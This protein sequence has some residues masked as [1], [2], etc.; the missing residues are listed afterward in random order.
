MELDGKWNKSY[1]FIDIYIHMHIYSLI[2]LKS[3]E[4]IETTDFD[5]YMT[6]EWT[7]HSSFSFILMRKLVWIGFC[8][9]I[10][11]SNKENEPWTFD[12]Y[13]YFKKHIS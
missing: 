13:F 11:Y 4:C 1:F 2:M 12:K 10:E 7:E 8:F 5:V 6:D 9:W 3:V